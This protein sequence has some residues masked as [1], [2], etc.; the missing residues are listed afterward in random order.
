MGLNTNETADGSSW[1][2]ELTDWQGKQWALGSNLLD[3]C[4]IS[5]NSGIFV[6]K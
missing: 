2:G 6:T 4:S 3:L 1:G 5:Y